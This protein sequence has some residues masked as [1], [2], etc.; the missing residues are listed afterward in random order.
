MITAK[1]LRQGPKTR[2]SDVTGP[3]K[4]Q[5]L[6]F[7]K[8]LQNDSKVEPSLMRLMTIGR[9]WVKVSGKYSPY[10]IQGQGSNN[11]GFHLHSS[12]FFKLNTNSVVL[13]PSTMMC[14]QE[15]N[16]EDIIPFEDTRKCVL[17]FFIQLNLC[18]LY[19]GSDYFNIHSK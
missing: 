2:D 4:V 13:N 19:K 6:L 5:L 7:F 10:I 15:G 12:P 17:S 16:T 18:I 1:L 11:Q 9:N 8:S 14:E 3:D